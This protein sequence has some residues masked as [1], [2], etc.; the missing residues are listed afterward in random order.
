MAHSQN[1][2]ICVAF[3]ISRML[4]YVCL[5]SCIQL[6][7]KISMFDVKVYTYNGRNSAITETIIKSLDKI[8]YFFG[9]LSLEEIAQTPP[10]VCILANPYFEDSFYKNISSKGIRIAYVPYG[11]SISGEDYTEE[12]QYHL[13]VHKIAWK[14]Y[15]SSDFYAKKYCKGNSAYDSRI[16]NIRTSPKFDHALKIQYKKNAKT[17]F[18]WNIHYRIFPTQQRPFSFSAFTAYYNDIIEFAN[19]YSDTINV[20]IRP[21]PGIFKVDDANYFLQY[22]RAFEG[23]ENISIELGSEAGYD[24]AFA[25]SD[26]LIT[27]LSSMMWDYLV[28]G[29]PIISLYYPLSAKLNDFAASA[30]EKYTYQAF[31]AGDLAQYMTDLSHGVDVLKQERET[32]LAEGKIFDISIPAAAILAKDMAQ[33]FGVSWL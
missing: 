7:S 28:T 1:K 16:I 13:P 20:C 14:I 9:E 8:E 33:S 19:K 10:D 4:D 21:H 6:F 30:F 23:C 26:V 32:M 22:L 24:K 2:K 15:A 31:T 11:L 5:E 17:T 3:V 27:D 29:K 25:R 18:L 12:L